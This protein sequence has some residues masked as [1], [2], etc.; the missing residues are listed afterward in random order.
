MPTP[1][2]PARH[3][4]S[5]TAARDPEPAASIG[6]IRRPVTLVRHR[7]IN[8][9]CLLRSPPVAHIPRPISGHSGVV[10]AGDSNG[11]EQ[12]ARCD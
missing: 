1:P 5:I 3:Q 12:R 2:L 9:A 6:Q 8:Q 7:P 4:E 11:K 10:R